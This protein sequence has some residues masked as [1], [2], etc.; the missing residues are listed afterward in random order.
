MHAWHLSLV[1]CVASLALSGPSPVAGSEEISTA[2]L[3]L[4]PLPYP[5]GY[6]PS[7]CRYE[8]R[9]EDLS[10]ESST[11][12]DSA[13]SGSKSQHESPASPAVPVQSRPPTWT[14]LLRKRQYVSEARESFL[15]S[16]PTLLEAARSITW[17]FS[18]TCRE[19][20][21]TLF[22]LAREVSAP[23]NPEFY[24]RI[25]VVY[26][27]DL[28]GIAYFEL[29]SRHYVKGTLYFERRGVQMCELAIFENLRQFV[30]DSVVSEGAVEK[31]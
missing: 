25:K 14:C 5:R 24:H 19:R 6:G 3:G 30:G 27:N 29:D 2:S 16:S 18:F 11:R 4:A 12:L 1:A 8:P 28:K 17:S 20:I 26:P 7:S 10:I 23:D 13:Y 22:I 21:E 9:A 31:E 15:S